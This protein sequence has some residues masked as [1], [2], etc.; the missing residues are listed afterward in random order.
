[1]GIK[2]KYNLKQINEK[3]LIDKASMKTRIEKVS[4]LKIS[5][6]LYA[7]YEIIE[8]CNQRCIFCYN[9]WKN[10][11]KNSC[12]K[13]ELTLK[14]QLKII[15]K[16]ARM[17][18]FGLI[19]SGGEPLISKNLFKIIERASKKYGIEVSII[20]NGTL[21]T[22]EVC[23]RLKENGLSDMQISLHSFKERDNNKITGMKNSF[24][25]TVSGIRNALK[26]FSPEN[27]NI[28]MVP[29]KKTYNQV[30]DTAKFLKNLGV[31]NFTVSS[32][33]YT[34]NKK[35][36]KELAPTKKQFLEIYNQIVKV[37]KELFMRTFI[38]GCYPLCS[39]K[40]KIDDE[41]ISL[42][43]N[44]CD[45]G[46]TQI[47]ISPKGDLRPCVA[48]EHILGNILEDDP[49][50]I[51]KNSKIL[52]KIRRMENIPLMCERCKHL[53]ICRGGC[54]ASAYNKS[55]RLDDIHQL[56]END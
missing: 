32:Y 15:D 35:L 1:M 4:C 50:K 22:E 43:G 47:V 9:V 34:G 41:V 27:I 31:I 40:K 28:N 24:G 3:F 11:K 18:I 6:P 56:I 45:A 38:G 14:Q 33:V 55:K 7:Q 53:V 46:V 13:R 51:W 21:L 17:K 48:Y 5:A 23:K 52:K 16:L 42:I 12:K 20:T 37:K 30:Y 8:N 39:L 54:R 2:E 36:D 29:T 25:R 44:I 26:Y 10:R 49:L 19:L